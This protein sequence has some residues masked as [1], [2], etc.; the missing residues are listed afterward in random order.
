MATEMGFQPDS[1]ASEILG[2]GESVVVS[3]LHKK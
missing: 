1:L 2:F 3:G